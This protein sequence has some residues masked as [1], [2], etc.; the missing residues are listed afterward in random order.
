MIKV[1]F[2]CSNLQTSIEVVLVESFLEGKKNFY[3]CH[4]SNPNIWEDDLLMLWST[5]ILYLKH[6]KIVQ[7]VFGLVEKLTTT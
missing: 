2:E 3:D 6:Y 1:S 4:T 5:S 7:H